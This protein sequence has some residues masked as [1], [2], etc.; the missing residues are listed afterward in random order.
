[1]KGGD[2]RKG[3]LDTQICNIYACFK[4]FH[5][6][7]N[8]PWLPL[9]FFSQIYEVIQAI[10]I[11]QQRKLWLGLLKHLSRALRTSWRILL[12]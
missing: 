10:R 3:H 11:W 12:K 4:I 8:F 6:F 2:G 1:M 7:P 5:S 9:K